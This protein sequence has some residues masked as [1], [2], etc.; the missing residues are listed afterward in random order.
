MYFDESREPLDKWIG[1]DIAVIMAVTGVFTMFFF[2]YPEPLL[3]A[4]TVATSALFRGG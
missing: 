2:I 1:R 3:S 4:A